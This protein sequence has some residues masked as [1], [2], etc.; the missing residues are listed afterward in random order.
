M[1]QLAAFGVGCFHFGIEVT[2]PYRFNAEDYTKSIE[3]FL[4]NLDT[5][6]SFSVHS[7]DFGA[8]TEFELTEVPPPLIEGHGFPLHALHS[9]EFSLR[10][11][12]RTQEDIIKGIHGPDYPWIGLGTE[13]FMVK[14]RYFYH[15]PV[16]LVQCL[17]IDDGQYEDPSDAVVVVREYH[18]KRSL[19]YRRR[20]CD[21]NS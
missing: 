15:G 13:H 17:D 10:I 7:S 14:T 16:T 11:P 4:G 3:G 8:Q 2:L 9:V 18:S 21:S 1:K 12:N 19:S 6:G 5:V 20:I